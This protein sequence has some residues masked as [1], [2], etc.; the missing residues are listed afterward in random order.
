MTYWMIVT[1]PE[2]YEKTRKLRFTQQGVKSRHRRKAERMTPGDRVCWYLTGIQA[3]DVL[4]GSGADVTRIEPD[5]TA[6]LLI[7]GQVPFDFAGVL[8]IDLE[9][10]EAILDSVARYAAQHSMV[11]AF[12]NY[13]CPTGGLASAGRSAMIACRASARA[14]S[15]APA[16]SSASCRSSV[17]TASRSSGRA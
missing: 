3:F 15:M 14:D 4:P 2:N 13:G 5:G 16:T 7:S 9:T 6:V 10:G 8:K 1:S 12:A 17:A 11:V